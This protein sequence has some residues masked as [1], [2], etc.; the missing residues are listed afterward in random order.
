M[1]VYVAGTNRESVKVSGAIGATPAVCAWKAVSR[2]KASHESDAVQ[3]L[4]INSQQAAAVAASILNRRSMNASAAA[5]SLLSAVTPFVYARTI[6][7]TTSGR[8]SI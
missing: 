8:S 3:R 7:F 4:R 6:D 1:A 2:F 5:R